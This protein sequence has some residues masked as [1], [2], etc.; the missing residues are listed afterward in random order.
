MQHSSSLRIPHFVLYILVFFLVGSYWVG[1]V[2]KGDIELF[3]NQ[4]HAPSLDIFFKYWTHLGDGLMFAA[5]VVVFLFFRYYYALMTIAII[6][7]Q[8]FFVQGMKRILFKGMLRP[9]AYL[10]QLGIS[11]LHFVEGVSVHSYNTFPSGHTASAFSIA[12]LLALMTRDRPLLSLWLFMVALL[13]GFSR[14]Y[15]MQH[16]FVDIYT[17]ALIG[18]LSTAFIWYWFER[19]YRDRLDTHWL[20]RSLIRRKAP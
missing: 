14:V 5:V 8:T 12:F 3:I 17:G 1:Y 19:A 4:R 7:T 10:E 18:T 9:S 6:L 16:F 2:P 20:G 13:V 11:D 15:L